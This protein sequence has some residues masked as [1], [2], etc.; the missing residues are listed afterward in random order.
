MCDCFVVLKLSPKR[1]IAEDINSTMCNTVS[2]VSEENLSF[3]WYIH[4]KAQCKYLKKTVPSECGITI[5]MQMCI[6]I[7]C[8]CLLLLS[9]IKQDFLYVRI[10]NRLQRRVCL[11][12][13][14]LLWIRSC[15]PLNQ[16][17]AALLWLSLSNCLIVFYCCY[18]FW[19]VT[20]YYSSREIVFQ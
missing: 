12:R 1:E 20:H 3:H 8:C 11:H 14:S 13:S 7:R 9:Y 5:I 19:N 10:V 18:C 15:F 6:M 2:L 17:E 16:V 4:S